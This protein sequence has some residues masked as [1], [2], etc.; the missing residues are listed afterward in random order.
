MVFTPAE[1]KLR[2][3][4]LPALPALALLAAPVTVELLAARPGGPDLRRAAVAA[5]AALVVVA[6]VVAVVRGHW[7][8]MSAS[9]R[10]TA[11]A[12]VAAFPGGLEG[13][14]VA[15][16]GVVGIVAIAVAWR[17][18]PLLLGFTA[19]AVAAWMVLGVPALDRAVS[20]RDSLKAFAATVAARHPPP[21]HV[22]FYGETIRPIAVY[23]G[24]PV[25]RADAASTGAAVITTAG[26]ALRLARGG[27]AAVPVLVAQGRV[28]NLSRATVVLL[29]S[30]GGER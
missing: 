2:Y 24:R 21:D 12:L 5:V 3:Y 20:R 15:A 14:A 22:V 4:L 6:G 16:G 7:S 9:D 13:L 27:T 25:P 26:G 10:R 18:W 11:T 1:W 8:P 28:G 30:T 19:A 17:A 29:E 23:L